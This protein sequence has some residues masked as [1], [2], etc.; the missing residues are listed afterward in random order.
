MP[1]E[2]AREIF[3]SNLHRLMDERRINQMDIANALR[4]TPSTVSDWYL[5]K[6]YPRVDTM[7]R[8]A[9][10]L[11]VPMSRLTT[12][13]STASI[14][15]I[16]EA[17]RRLIQAYRAADETAQKYALEMLL[18]HPRATTEENLA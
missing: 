14:D 1:T 5:G 3:V 6:K 2:T 4:I 15:E 8:L 17:E 18:A 7:Q 10:L 16:S 9:D 13:V 12:A 11:D